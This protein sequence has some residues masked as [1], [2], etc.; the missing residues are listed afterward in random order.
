MSHKKV[1]ETDASSPFAGFRLNNCTYYASFLTPLAT[2]NTPNALC[3]GCVAVQFDNASAY[4]K[5]YQEYELSSFP[6]TTCC[7]KML[8][9]LKMLPPKAARFLGGGGEK[10][11]AMLHACRHSMH[12][13]ENNSCQPL[14][15][16]TRRSL[17]AN[18]E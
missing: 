16:C 13:A 8:L 6:Y 12:T 10:D 7:L 9:S 3:D 4:M 17:S 18:P 2:M 14:I 5:L 15:S 1:A 11:Q